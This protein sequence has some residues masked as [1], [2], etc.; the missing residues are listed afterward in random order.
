MQSTQTK[1]ERFLQGDNSVM[2]DLL[3]LFRDKVWYYLKAKIPY[4]DVE[5]LFHDV[6][7]AGFN[8]LP[9]LQEPDKLL[10]WMLAITR[11]KIQEYYKKRDVATTSYSEEQQ[12]PTYHPK[13]NLSQEKSIKLNKIHGCINQLR[14][15]F[16]E[17][18]ILHFILGMPY[19]EVALMMGC[20]DNTAK[21]RIN[22]AKVMIFK[23]SGGK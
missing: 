23:C 13:K 4:D 22:R 14:E 20:N 8:G 3:S 6:V 15:P 10:P 19:P 11:R 5:D 12:E 17:V 9:R 1:I 16:R 21:S 7:I 2:E 18:A